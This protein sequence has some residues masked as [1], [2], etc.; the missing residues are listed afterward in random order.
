VNVSDS[1]QDSELVSKTIISVFK[2]DIGA[3]HSQTLVRL[4]ARMIKERKFMVHPNA[5]A[6]LLHLRLR[7]ELDTTEKTKRK[8]KGKARDDIKFKSEKRKEWM[9]KNMK[10]A[11]KEKKEIEKDLDEAAAE[12]DVEERASIVSHQDTVSCSGG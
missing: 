1:A 6:P 7:S 4:L 3:Q 9:T 5:L 10:K 11:M 2:A 12:V 8:G